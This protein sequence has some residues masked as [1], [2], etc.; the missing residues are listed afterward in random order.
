MPT[1][2]DVS[3]YTDDSTEMSHCATF[4]RNGLGVQERSIAPSI[5][6]LNGQ[7]HQSGLPYGAFRRDSRVAAGIVLALSPQDAADPQVVCYMEAWV[8][9]AV[10]TVAE[11]CSCSG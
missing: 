2:A 11:G 3:F 5:I 4:P 9:L 7:P 6:R 1:H 8:S 10:V